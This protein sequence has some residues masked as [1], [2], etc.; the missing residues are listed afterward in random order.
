MIEKL[1]D[2]YLFSDIDGTLGVS[3][4]GIPERNREAVARFVEKGGHF[5]IA[6]GRTVD[7]AR[8]FTG[9][10]GINSPCILSNG[11]A[12]YDYGLEEYYFTSHL[13]E[14]APRYLA[15]ILRDYP[16]IGA[17]AVNATDY[18]YIGERSQ[19]KE[20]FKRS[21]TDFKLIQPEDFTSDYF[22]VLFAVPDEECQ[23]ILQELSGRGYEGVYFVSSDTFYIEMLPVG[24]SK[25][26]SIR[27]LCK[28]KNI[29]IDHTIAIGDYYNDAELL[30]AAGFA[31]TVA[32]APQE[33][34]AL[35]DLVVGPCMDGAVADLIEYLEERYDR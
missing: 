35:C 32:E 9:E 25:G 2:I 4:K 15:E 33:I 21:H 5:A 22:K 31:V 7:N 17:A 27:K 20:V 28:L 14:G 24:A 10:I 23:T 16:H 12:V 6:T 18:C 30:K 26:D 34:K 11:C 13:P 1:S 8:R 29:P 3:G 19:V